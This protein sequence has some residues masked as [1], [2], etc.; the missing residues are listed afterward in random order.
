MPGRGIADIVHRVKLC[1]RPAEPRAASSGAVT[2]RQ[3]VLP[4]GG[5]AYEHVHHQGGDKRDRQVINF[6][7]ADSVVQGRLQTM[8]TAKPVSMPA[9]HPAYEARFHNKAKMTCGPKEAP[10]ILHPYSST[11]E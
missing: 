2:G 5:Q 3:P 11:Y 10:S 9:T 6:N 7:A 1:L 8:V 4:R